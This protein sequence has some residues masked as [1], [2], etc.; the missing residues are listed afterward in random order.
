MCPKVD[1]QISKPLTHTVNTSLQ[2]ILCVGSLNRKI[3]KLEIKMFTNNAA[4][5]L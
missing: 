1:F 4:T 3:E 2:N 5:S